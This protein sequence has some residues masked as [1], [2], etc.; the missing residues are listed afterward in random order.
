MKNFPINPHCKNRPL[1]QRRVYRH[2][3]AKVIDFSNGGLCGNMSFLSDPTEISYL[4]TQRM[5]TYIM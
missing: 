2:D 3:V 4:T 5:L 1:W